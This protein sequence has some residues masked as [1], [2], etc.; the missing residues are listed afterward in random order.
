MT[1]YT[2]NVGR[3]LLF[4]LFWFMLPSIGQIIHSILSSLSQ[5]IQVTKKNA[6][7]SKNNVGKTSVAP[8]TKSSRWDW[9]EY[10]RHRHE[11]AFVESSMWLSMGDD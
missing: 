3:L 10:R 9:Q 7:K 8:T 6:T 11:D 5:P 2:F 4:A 1:E